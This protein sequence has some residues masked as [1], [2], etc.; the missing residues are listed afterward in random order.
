MVAQASITR[1]IIGLRA[2]AQL[3]DNLGA[4][5]VEISDE[6]RKQIDALAPPGSA[7][8]KLPND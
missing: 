4:I 6:D 1:A 3:Q 5:D 8:A 2:L 7:L